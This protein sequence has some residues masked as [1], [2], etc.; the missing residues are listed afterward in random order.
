M[1]TIESLK[2]DVKAQKELCEEIWATNSASS[3]EY[4]AAKK[5]YNYL[6]N[7]LKRF[8]H[9]APSNGLTFPSI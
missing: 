9:P 2:Q 7:K 5:R 4:R 6:A 8:A 1:T 3:P